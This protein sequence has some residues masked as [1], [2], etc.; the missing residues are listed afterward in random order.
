MAVDEAAR[1]RLHTK[2]EEI[3]GTE[4]AAALMTYLPPVGWAD[5]ARKRDLDV[6]AEKID[7]KTDQI[8]SELRSEMERL[9]RRLVMWMSSMIVA[10][11]GLAF[12][13]GRL[14]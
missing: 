12:V 4:E 5:V 3:L 6:L 13:V 11:V 9:A 7:L 2:L 8:R 1:H 10:A 14:T